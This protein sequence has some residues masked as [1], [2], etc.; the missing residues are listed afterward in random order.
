MADRAIWIVAGRR[1][2]LPRV[3]SPDERAIAVALLVIV[4]GE[5]VVSAI[6]TA[7][8]GDYSSCIVLTTARVLRVSAGK[9]ECIAE[10]RSIGRVFVRR[11]WYP[12]AWMLNLPY[13]PDFVVVL[14]WEFESIVGLPA[15]QLRTQGFASEMISFV[16]FFDMS[17]GSRLIQRSTLPG[18]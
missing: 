9:C 8:R 2:Q 18:L 6:N 14:R 4:P 3:V 5:S 15:T 12:L 1:K 16:R 7:V 13:R 10:L 17:F 11:V